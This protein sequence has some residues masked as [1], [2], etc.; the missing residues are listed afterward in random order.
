ME[1]SWTL[2]AMWYPR[3]PCDRPELPQNSMQYLSNACCTRC[4][5]QWVEEFKIT[6]GRHYN[7]LNL[8]IHYFIDR[9]FQKL[10]TF[11]LKGSVSFFRSSLALKQ[12]VRHFCFAIILWFFSLTFHWITFALKQTS[13]LHILLPC[14]QQVLQDFRQQSFPDWG[15]NKMITRRCLDKFIWFQTDME[16]KKKRLSLKHPW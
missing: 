7:V 9:K 4:H 2:T 10:F 14:R 15:F 11:F 1:L 3:Q 12:P 5:V 13:S 8:K 16:K 6:K